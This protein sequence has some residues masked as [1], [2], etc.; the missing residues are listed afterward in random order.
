MTKRGH[1]DGAPSQTLTP[2]A[3][4]PERLREDGDRHRDAG[5]WNAAAASYRSYIAIMPTDWPI[6]VQ[7]G[8]CVKEAGSPEEA[9]RLYRRA[10]ALAPN[11]S[12]LKVQIGHA[13]KLLGRST[14]ALASY[15]AALRIDPESEIAERELLVVLE[16]TSL[17]E[18]DSPANI[19][20]LTDPEPW[21]QDIAL[22]A[23]GVAELG[24]PPT[25]LLPHWD[26]PTPELAPPELLLPDLL[27]DIGDLVA[28]LA[29]ARRPT[30]LQRVQIEV[31]R[32]ALSDPGPDN[33]AVLA[34]WP[35][36]GA[37]HWLA[38]DLL[39]ALVRHFEGPDTIDAPIDVAGLVD[40]LRAARCAESKTAVWPGP[41]DARRLLGT[42][43]SRP[44]RISRPSVGAPLHPLRA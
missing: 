17:A 26:G 42:S 4:T 15:N 22:E 38:P 29:E 11:D 1:L 37:W 3:I 28:H 33:V 27:L 32:A 9:L 39:Q 13:L 30:G 31:V 35:E 23:E 10:E 34:F 8:H 41:G 25:I 44:R 12:D 2:A 43:G 16:A 5:Q 19:G 14:E 20:Y 36:S 40:A 7:L 24:P 18:A 21:M 6:I